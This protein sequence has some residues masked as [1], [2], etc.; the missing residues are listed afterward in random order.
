MA[1]SFRGSGASR[2]VGG[3]IQELYAQADHLSVSEAEAATE[4]I[5]ALTTA[6]AR[7]RLAGDEADHVKSRKKAALDYVDA[8]LGDEQLGPNE[9][10]DAAHVSPASLYR[11]LAAEGGIGPVLLKLAHI[12][13]IARRRRATGASQDSPA[14]GNC[15]PRRELFHT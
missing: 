10:A 4:G 2:L 3:A 6:F 11:L 1:L 14:H 5:E 8:H 12:G 13:E 9:I 7:A 15:R